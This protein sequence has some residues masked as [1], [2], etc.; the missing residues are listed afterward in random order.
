[1]LNKT[2]LPRVDAQVLTDVP[3]DAFLANLLALQN[4]SL[5]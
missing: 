2:T 3:Q 5:F 4:V 1:M